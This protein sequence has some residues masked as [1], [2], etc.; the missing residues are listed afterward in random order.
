MALV[1]A[2]FKLTVEF[3]DNGGNIT[4]R[5]YDMRETVYA[6]ALVDAAAAVAAVDTISLA[7]IRSYTVA[8]QFVEDA[9]SVPASGIQ[10]EDTAVVSVTLASNPLKTATLSI[11]A[12]SSGIFT[13]TSGFNADVVD[14]ADAALV[15]FVDLFK[16]A[17]TLYISDGE[18]AAATSPIAAGRRVHRRS[19]KR[20]AVLQG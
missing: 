4:T 6:D 3:V 19:G 14:V 1:S 10:N 5:S 2:G 8:E 13:G 20:R 11:P 9:F 15:A 7:N 12:P 16:A 17:G 18:A